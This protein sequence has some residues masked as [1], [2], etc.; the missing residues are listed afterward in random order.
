MDHTSSGTGRMLYD[1]PSNDGS[2]PA[3]MANSLRLVMNHDGYVIWLSLYLGIA[4]IA[5]APPPPPPPPSWDKIPTFTIF[6]PEASLSFLWYLYHQYL[7]IIIILFPC[8]EKVF[9]CLL[10]LQLGS[11]LTACRGDKNTI[12]V[13]YISHLPCLI[14]SGRTSERQS[15]LIGVGW[16]G[17]AWYDFF[18]VTWK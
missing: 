9:P 4:Q 3:I 18:F 15:T 10:I 1:S 14:W 8:S 7:R 13:K 12:H 16:T 6:C 11:I 17:K 2:T 5:I